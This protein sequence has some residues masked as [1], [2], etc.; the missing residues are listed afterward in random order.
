V[1]VQE[2]KAVEAVA[3]QRVHRVADH[4][5]EGRGLE[6]DRAGEAQVVL[7]HADAD[8]GRDQRLEALAQALG[9]RLRADG[10]GAEQTVGAMLLGRADRKDDGRRAL[11]IGVD[12]LPGLELQPHGPAS[13]SGSFSRGIK[14]L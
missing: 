6:A 12:L 1:A 5:H 9:H 4:R 14:D 11:Q 2:I 7:R 10:V 3:R 8:G 13:L